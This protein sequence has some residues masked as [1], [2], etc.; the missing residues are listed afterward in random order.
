MRH[1]QIEKKFLEKKFKEQFCKKKFWKK[2]SKY[3]HIIL[4]Y[5]NYL[6][7]SSK[8]TTKKNVKFR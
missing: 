5:L 4:I 6:K 7:N 3:I 1:I 8:M 2:K